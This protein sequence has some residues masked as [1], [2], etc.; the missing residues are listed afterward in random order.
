MEKKETE[1]KE[2]Y[3]AVSS[4]RS[5]TRSAHQHWPNL[6]LR[7]GASSSSSGRQAARWSTGGRSIR[8]RLSDARD[9]GR[10]PLSSIKRVPPLWIS[11]SSFPSPRFLAGTKTLALAPRVPAILGH[12]KLRRVV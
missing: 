7:V 8:R 11:P 9:E 5:P 1:K 12:P 2:T 3:L 10:R 4:R 6:P